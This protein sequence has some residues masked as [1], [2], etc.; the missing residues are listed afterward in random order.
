LDLVAQVI[1]RKF[2]Q[3]C[4]F[5]QLEFLVTI[6][7]RIITVLPVTPIHILAIRVIIRAIRIAVIPLI[8]VSTNLIHLFIQ[9]SPIFPP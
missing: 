5:S 6:P 3:N 1:A 4:S 2:L 7:G 8:Q 9:D